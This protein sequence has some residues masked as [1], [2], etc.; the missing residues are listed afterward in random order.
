MIPFS[1]IGVGWG[2]FLHDFPIN[3]S[4]M[5]GIIA[6][7][8]IMVNDGLVLIGKFN[9]LLGEGM[10]FNEALYEAAK[11]DLEPYF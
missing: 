8:G 9:S 5:L 4:S 10:P 11:I 2:H 7:I 3:I 1:F 6:L